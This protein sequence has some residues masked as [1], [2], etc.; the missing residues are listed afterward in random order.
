MSKEVT[1]TLSQES[2]RAVV[3]AVDYA[4]NMGYLMDA[5][6]P[7]GRNENADKQLQEIREA[8]LL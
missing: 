8:G 7:D 3:S 6:D 5:I 4:H 2:Y 1:I